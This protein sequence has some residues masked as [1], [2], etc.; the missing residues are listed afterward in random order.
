MG[1]GTRAFGA[2]EAAVAAGEDSVA[3]PVEQLAG[4]L[5]AGLDLGEDDGSLALATIIGV[6]DPL[7]D[8]DMSLCRNRPEHGEALLGMQNLGEVPA[9]AVIR[10]RLAL[11]DHCGQ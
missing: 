9:A 4:V 11:G 1:L 2:T 8:H 3:E 5:Q 7:A 10:Q 6:L